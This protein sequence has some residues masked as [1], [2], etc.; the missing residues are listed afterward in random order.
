MNFIRKMQNLF[1]SYS[2]RTNHEILPEIVGKAMQSLWNDNGVQ[3]CFLRSREY[4][5]NDSAA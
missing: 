4:Q 2:N 1:L 5:L 3:A